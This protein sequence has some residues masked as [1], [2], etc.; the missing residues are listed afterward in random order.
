[1]RPTNMRRPR[2]VRIT[3]GALA[4]AVPASAVALSVG[5]ADAVDALQV[6]PA[7]SKLQADSET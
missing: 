3:A 7:A 1:M 2:T 6:K 4:I 5:Q